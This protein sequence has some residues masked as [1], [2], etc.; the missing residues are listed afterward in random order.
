MINF[1]LFLDSERSYWLCYDAFDFYVFNVYKLI[2]EF[3][4]NNIQRIKTF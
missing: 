2:T 3:R 1:P 4:L